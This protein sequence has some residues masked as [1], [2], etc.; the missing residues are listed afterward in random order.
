L[1]CV[2]EERCI[3]ER[4]RYCPCRIEHS[5]LVLRGH[6]NPESRV[7]AST[8]RELERINSPLCIDLD[9]FNLSAYALERAPGRGMFDS[10]HEHMIARRDYAPNYRV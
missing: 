3:A 9:H 10:A 2:D 7:R 8:S 1:R 4:V 6:H 5:K